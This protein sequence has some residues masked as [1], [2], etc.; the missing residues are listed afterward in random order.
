M[1]SDA[2]CAHRYRLLLLALLRQI[3]DAIDEELVGTDVDSAGVYH[4]TAELHQL[5]EKN[6]NNNFKGATKK[7]ILFTELLY[8]AQLLIE[9]IKN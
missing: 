2:S 1:R 5:V 6:R 8:N 3:L 9:T 4:P 7:I